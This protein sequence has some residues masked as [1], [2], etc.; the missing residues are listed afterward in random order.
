MVTVNVMGNR[1]L[2]KEQLSE[3][4]EM[5]HAHPTLVSL[6]GIADDATQANLS[7]LWMDADDAVVLADELPAKGALTSLNLSMNELCGIDEDGD[8]EYD[9][10]GVTALADAIGK[11]Q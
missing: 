6:F 5:M 3:L 4:Q 2:G 7:D 8:G 1:D 11:H 9:A 10:S